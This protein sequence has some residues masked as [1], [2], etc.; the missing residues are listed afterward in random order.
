VQGFALALAAVALAAWLA[1]DWLQNRLHAREREAAN[2]LTQNMDVEDVKRIV[3]EV[4]ICPGDSRCHKSDTGRKRGATGGSKCA[5]GGEPVQR[6][7]GRLVYLAT[8]RMRVSV[9]TQ[10]TG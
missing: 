10:L 5:T 1:W 2:T 6:S 9:Y 3:G 8:L 7:K 4:C